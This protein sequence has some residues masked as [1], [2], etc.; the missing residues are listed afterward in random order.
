MKLFCPFS[1]TLSKYY[2]QIIIHALLQNELQL[3]PNHEFACSIL[4]K[5]LFTL[6]IKK[7]N[8]KKKKRER[9]ALRFWSC[10]SAFCTF[11]YFA[12]CFLEV[13]C[14]ICVKKLFRI[15]FFH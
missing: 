5:P 13:I 14:F 2:H 7:I 1:I 3:K 12:V 6:K 8:L 11:P 4:S 9:K 15:L 10:Y